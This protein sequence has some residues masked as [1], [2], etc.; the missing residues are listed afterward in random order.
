MPTTITVP[1]TT[2]D[3]NISTTEEPTGTYPTY[4]TITEPTTT[5]KWDTTLTQAPVTPF[6]LHCPE[7]AMAD[8]EV[9]DAW[10]GTLLSA[11]L[12]GTSPGFAGR[13]TFPVYPLPASYTIA[14]VLPNQS[15]NSI[16]TTWNMQFYS[17]FNLSKGFILHSMAQPI[18]S[19]D[20]TSF[21]FILTDVAKPTDVKVYFWPEEVND[22]T[23][24]ALKD[25]TTTN[26]PSSRGSSLCDGK[27]SII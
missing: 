16:I 7:A 1:V 22:D 26:E 3:P 11:K 17:Y 18:D 19:N 10:G 9:L 25:E 20:P 21:V 2:S 23:C 6:P 14:I 24:F 4:S 13:I 12:G 5:T 15:P 8:L 27:L